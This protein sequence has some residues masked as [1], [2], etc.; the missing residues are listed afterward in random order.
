MTALPE[1]ATP[2]WQAAQTFAVGADGLNE[3]A[4]PGNAETVGTCNCIPNRISAV[5]MPVNNRRT[6]E[7][8]FNCITP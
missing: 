4:P 5:K 3:P 1:P 6:G 8:N 2:L 7:R